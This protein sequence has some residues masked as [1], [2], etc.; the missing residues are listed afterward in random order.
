MCVVCSYVNVSPGSQE[1]I[2]G[3]NSSSNS[4][5]QRPSVMLTTVHI[6]EK[7][8]HLPLSVLKCVHVC[9]C[10]K[11]YVCLLELYC[12]VPCRMRWGGS[13]MKI[14]A[15]SHTRVVRLC[16]ERGLI[17]STEQ[18]LWRRGNRGREKEQSKIKP[19]LV[20]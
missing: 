3:D 7:E 1:K 8:M 6:L 17:Y 12:N 9:T 19:C 2:K 11:M 10:E 20:P 14:S 5:L 15:L 13:R 4:F 16:A 18:L